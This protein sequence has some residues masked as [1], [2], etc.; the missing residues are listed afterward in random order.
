MIEISEDD[1]SQTSFFLFSLINFNL[2]GST[3]LDLKFICLEKFRF[4][5][6][7]SCVDRYVQSQLLLLN[8]I[9]AVVESKLWVVLTT[10][11][12]YHHFFFKN[13]VD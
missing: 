3:F 8:L 13:N 9:K 4:I 1:R 5:H 12:V 11:W 7:T 10:S 6:F 2:L